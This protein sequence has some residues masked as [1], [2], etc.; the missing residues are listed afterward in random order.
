MVDFYLQSWVYSYVLAILYC[1]ADNY[2]LIAR[3]MKLSRAYILQIKS[4][5]VRSSMAILQ[6]EFFSGSNRVSISE[7]RQKTGLEKP[8]ITDRFGDG[9]EALEA[10]ITG[11]YRELF[12]VIVHLINRSIASTARVLNTM[13]I[14]DSPGFQ[15]VGSIKGCPRKSATFDELCYNYAQERLMGLHF[16]ECFTQPMEIYHQEQIAV[17]FDDPQHSPHPIIQLLDKP[18]QQNLVKNFWQNFCKNISF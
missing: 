15:N 17:D 4:V 9:L 16:D 6:L 14:V 1:L 8:A 13:T 7:L 11:L 3:N 10:F 2:Q 5:S 12:A 18:S